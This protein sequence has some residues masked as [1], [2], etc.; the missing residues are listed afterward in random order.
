MSE[1]FLIMRKNKSINPYGPQL[2]YNVPRNPNF[3]LIKVGAHVVMEAEIGGEITFVGY[4]DIT[5]IEPNKYAKEER[6]GETI[7]KIKK[8]TKF[9]PPRQ[10]NEEIRLLLNLIPGYSWFDSVRLITKEAYQKILNFC[11]MEL[12]DLPTKKQSS[13]NA[14][15]FLVDLFKKEESREFEFKSTLRTPIEKDKVLLALESKVANSINAQERAKH[16]A[17]L[18][19]YVGSLPKE[20]E[21]EVLKTIAAFSNSRGGGI[22]LIGVDDEEHLVGIEHDYRSF[23]RK[24]NWDGWLGTLKDLVKQS[25]GVIVATALTVNPYT[26]TD[27]TLA[28]IKVPFAPEPIFFKW[29]NNRGIEL[30]EFYV[31]IQ[32]STHSLS[33]SD[34]YKYIKATWK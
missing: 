18:R 31:R 3:H 23:A 17:E 21:H 33:R 34:Q 20:L 14:H 29:K 24:Q 5:S 7:T 15:D 19:N 27:K 28:V 12:S 16:E 4:G 8:F 22:L 32:N 25:L 26:I 1:T 10:K 13:N 2:F 30:E 9:Y 11:G 6:R